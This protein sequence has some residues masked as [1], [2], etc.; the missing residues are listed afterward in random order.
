MDAEFLLNRR[1]ELKRLYSATWNVYLINRTY[2][3]SLLV[4]YFK[5]LLKLSRWLWIEEVEGESHKEVH[6]TIYWCH[7]HDRIPCLLV[8]IINTVPLFLIIEKRTA[9]L[10]LKV[11]SSNN[12][13]KNGMLLKR[14]NYFVIEKY[15]TSALSS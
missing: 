10:N 1:I 15:T 6:L 11:I 4:K 3:R 12:N 9:I 13:K 5:R 14:V 7:I 2:F 8:I